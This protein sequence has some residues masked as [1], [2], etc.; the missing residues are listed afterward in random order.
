[1]TRDKKRASLREALCGRGSRV[2]A[3]YPPLRLFEQRGTQGER[4][5][6]FRWKRGKYV[7]EHLPS[8]RATLGS[9]S[10]PF[11]YRMASRAK[12]GKLLSLPELQ[13]NHHVTPTPNPHRS[14]RRP[15]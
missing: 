4:G 12:G 10:L 15:P 2:E 13:T 14:P 5:S 11:T 6:P 9:L 8:M 1:M 7:R 3:V